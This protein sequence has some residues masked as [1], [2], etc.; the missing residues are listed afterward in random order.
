M[1]DN[2]RK[3]DGTA[4]RL[5]INYTHL[6]SEYFVR[7]IGRK[8]NYSKEEKIVITYGVE[9]LFNT[10]LKSIVYIL[11]GMLFHQ[12][13]ETFISIFV[14]GFLRYFTGGMHTKTDIGCFLITG[15]I[16]FGAVFVPYVWIV[17]MWGYWVIAIAASFAYICFSGW[18]KGIAAIA[19][20]IAGVF[21]D[22]YWR[23]FV[24]MIVVMQGITIFTGGY[25]NEK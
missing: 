8:R 1:F 22:D 17:P 16:V 25:M 13:L 12:T 24:L 11:L 3:N 2:R 9:L 23:M 14:F 20:L 15:G 5:M 7:I 10:L 21:M 4:E 18:K 6:I 19:S